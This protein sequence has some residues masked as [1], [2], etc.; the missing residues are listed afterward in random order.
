MS[1]L[2]GEIVN[3]CFTTRCK[4]DYV[5]RLREEH[6][7]DQHVLYTTDGAHAFYYYRSADL[8]EIEWEDEYRF[9]LQQPLWTDH[10]T[11]ALVSLGCGNADPEK[12][13]LAR[14][15]ADGRGIAYVGVDT[16][17]VMLDL[18]QR[19]LNGAPY[20]RSY[21]LGDFTTAA[22]R[23]AIAPLLAPYDARVYTMI[24]G[25]FGNFEQRR[26]GEAL[27][28][29]IAPGDYL[30]LDVVPKAQAEQELGALKSR[31]A[32]LPQNYRRFF[33]NLLER[34]NVPQE[35]VK[36][37]SQEQAEPA[38]LDTLRTTFFIE[39]QQEVTLTYFG[40]R[41]TLAAG[42][43]VEVLN[44]RAYDP[45]SLKAFMAE[46]GFR[47]VGEFLPRVGALKHGWYRLLL[48][49]DTP[50]EGEEHL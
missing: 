5:T 39:P 24:G 28:R 18:A 12:P 37:V 10:E 43:H 42:E 45:T 19:N 41:I 4:R 25:T 26:I 3:L 31:F 36:I 8:K 40:E 11:V 38:G 2:K 33:T 9:F 49:R 1:A 15:H 6:V 7:I 13:L 22:F 44:I 21:V 47:F 27:R 30:Y 20:P 34:L 32:R 14:L 50:G 17:K 46:H 23:D 16:S 35:A 48:Q 29:L